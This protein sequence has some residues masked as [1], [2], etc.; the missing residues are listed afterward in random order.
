[1]IWSCW[2]C[3]NV[4]MIH[5]TG[6]LFGRSSGHVDLYCN[7][8]KAGYRVAMREIRP[9]DPEVKKRADEARRLR[10]SNEPSAPSAV[11]IKREETQS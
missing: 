4:L 9:P 10:M 3:S 5:D 8:C 6:Q 11:M 1:M 7:V 2:T